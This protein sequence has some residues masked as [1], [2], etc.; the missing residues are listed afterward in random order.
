M[1]NSYFNIIDQKYG[2]QNF[3][4]KLNIDKRSDIDGQVSHTISANWNVVDE[5]SGIAYCEWAAGLQQFG[6]EVF[7]FTKTADVLKATSTMDR[8]KVFN[9]KIYLTIRCR[10]MAGLYT[11]ACSDGIVIS[12]QSPSARNAELEILPQSLTEYQPSNFHQA[13]KTSVKMKWSEF[14]DPFGIMSF[15]VKFDGKDTDI[16]TSILNVNKDISYLSLFGLKLS[17]DRYTATVNAV[18]TMYLRSKDVTTNLT[19]QNSTPGLTGADAT[20]T[21]KEDTITV[22]WKDCFSYPRRVVFEI[23]IGTTIG[24]ADIIQWQETLN[25]YIEVEVPEKFKDDSEVKLFFYIRAIGESGESNSLN[26]NT[27][28]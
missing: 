25:D 13:S 10:N 27:V 16:T 17:D 2:Y 8:Y 9:K 5:E 20:I 14:S 12:D 15:I 1:D 6:N 26:A 18:N 24:G 19:I 22:N 4:S 3:K 11:T 21:R 23:S 7:E 28:L